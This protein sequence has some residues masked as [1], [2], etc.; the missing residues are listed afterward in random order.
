MR[1]N[2]LLHCGTYLPTLRFVADPHHTW[3]SREIEE[4]R[5]DSSPWP[6][7]DNAT[8]TNRSLTTASSLPS[9][10]PLGNKS[11]IGDLLCRIG[12]IQGGSRHVT[13]R[14]L[15]HTTTHNTEGRASRS[16]T[17]PLTHNTLR[18]VALRMLALYCCRYHL[19]TNFAEGTTLPVHTDGAHTL[20]TASNITVQ[21]RTDEIMWGSICQMK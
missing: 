7:R 10:V 17:E 19:Y 16:A 8:T 12:V 9:R 3:F 2:L 13:S 5:R 21:G 18:Q 20:S 15:L 6:C 1:S 11:R 14:Q 4:Y